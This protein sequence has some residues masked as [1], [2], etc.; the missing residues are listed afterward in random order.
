MKKVE[1]MFLSLV[2]FCD[3]DM[4]GS[5]FLR[6]SSSSSQFDE[7]DAF[8][9]VDDELSSQDF[10]GMP[11]I[12]DIPPYEETSIFDLS[13][14]GQPDISD[15]G[16][17]VISVNSQEEETK[18][19]ADLLEHHFESLE[20]RKK[21]KQLGDLTRQDELS[22]SSFNLDKSSS[23]SNA[24]SPQIEPSP[25]SPKDVVDRVAVL[26]AASDLRH[27][28]SLSRKVNA[29]ELAL[30]ID[31]IQE[32]YLNNIASLQWVTKEFEKIRLI[33]EQ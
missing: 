3:Y 30:R 26:L 32:L 27:K 9:S 18:V 29:Q 14:Y 25:A 33:F 21:R 23:S 15:F 10:I 7:M 2:F 22:L 1:I 24:L 19:Y 11:K 13:R 20:S 16:S 17:E 6:R 28:V 4:Q 5:D 12:V 8:D 31:R